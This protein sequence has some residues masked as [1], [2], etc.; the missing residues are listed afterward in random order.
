MNEALLL[1]LMNAHR[2]GIE[3]AKTALKLVLKEVPLPPEQVASILERLDR[4]VILPTRV[5]KEIFQPELT[6]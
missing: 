3:D 1:N 4:T 5:Y 6:K 2:I